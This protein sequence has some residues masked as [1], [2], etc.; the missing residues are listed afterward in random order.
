MKGRREI[1]GLSKNSWSV[2][3][4]A[5]LVV[6]W[7][8]YYNILYYNWRKIMMK[9]SLKWKRHSADQLQTGTEL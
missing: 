1:R 4:E 3:R 6:H 2:E 9:R 7:L 5:S 8:I